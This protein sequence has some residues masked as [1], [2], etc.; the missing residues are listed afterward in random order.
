MYDKLTIKIS[1]TNA[2]KTATVKGINFN[3]D[4]MYPTW[5]F[6]SRVMTFIQPRFPV[7]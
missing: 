5:Y 1:F 3:A 4:S 7:S 6:Y 2:K